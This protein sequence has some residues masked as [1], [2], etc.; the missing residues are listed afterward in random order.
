MAKTL[1]LKSFFGFTRHPFPP[2]CPPEPLFEGDWTEAALESL[3]TAVA[4]RLHALVVAP[5]GSGKSC[6]IRLLVGRLN[7]R[8]FL[9]ASLV[10][11][12]IGITEWVQRV[13]EELGIETAGRRGAA[14]KLLRRGLGGLR[15]FPVLIIDEAG[16]VSLEAIDLVRSLVEE[17]AR[18]LASLVLVGDEPFARRLRKQVHAPLWQRL[19]ARVELR[20]L[21][22]EQAAA[23]IE[24][25]FTIAGM[26]NI[27][28]PAAAAP[29]YAATGGSPRQIGSVIAAAMQLA[30][31]NRSKL[32]TDEII[33]QVLD[34]NGR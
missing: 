5:P 32:L 11:Q 16:Q 22:E 24:H 33:Q 20:P 31:R 12:P 25:A 15:R 13:A 14:V 27:L 8:D 30:L 26:S 6:L 17:A 34:G 21:S 23:F 4:H 7:P 2:A 10:G 18:P 19:A 9:V 1:T 3:S 29:V 28:S